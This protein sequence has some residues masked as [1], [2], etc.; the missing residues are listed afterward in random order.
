M[1]SQRF[2]IPQVSMAIPFSKH[3]PKGHTSE[4]GWRYGKEMLYAKMLF[5]FI[6]LCDFFLA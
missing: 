4:I 5:Y 1:D 6:V 2:S 3:S